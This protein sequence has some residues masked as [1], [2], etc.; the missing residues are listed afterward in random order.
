MDSDT[1]N[2]VYRKLRRNNLNEA[3][4]LVADMILDRASDREAAML[5]ERGYT[6]IE[7]IRAIRS[8]YDLDL[9]GAKEVVDR[10][11]E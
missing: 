2:V 10:V 4:V 1:L 8:R 3:A 6:Y 11:R 5:L 9:K 7:V